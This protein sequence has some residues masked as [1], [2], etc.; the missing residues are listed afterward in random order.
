M[1]AERQSVRSWQVGFFDWP[2]FRSWAKGGCLLFGLL[3]LGGCAYYSTSATS[4][5]GIRTVAV[6]LLEN[7]SLEAGIQQTLTD[8]LIQGFVTNGALRVVAEDQ[9]D[10]MLQGR[11]LEVREDPFTYGDRAD[12][13]QISVF[14]KV[15]FYDARQK[16]AIWEVDRMRGYGIYNAANQRE[17]ERQKGLGDALR[18]VVQDVI[19]RTQVG[20]W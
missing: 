9:A 20:G 5:G 16:Q 7:E 14:V 13:F 3:F 11:V 18:M 8:S 1:I 6:P 17:A 2:H 19:D 4:G 12:Q 15:V 10:A